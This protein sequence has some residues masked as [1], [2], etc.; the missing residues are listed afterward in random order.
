MVNLDGTM[1]KIGILQGINGEHYHGDHALPHSK[2]GKTNLKNL[3]ILTKK[4]N[5]KKSDL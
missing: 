5:L 2:G 3:Q 1:E 4:D